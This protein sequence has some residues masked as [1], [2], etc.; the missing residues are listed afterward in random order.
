MRAPALS[1]G[2][3]D[4]GPVPNTPLTQGIA[5]VRLLL[6]KGYALGVTQ[7]AAELGQPKSSLHR[8]LQTLTGTPDLSQGQC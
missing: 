4:R 7:I 5:V 3:P 2:M 8:L 1:D 6:H